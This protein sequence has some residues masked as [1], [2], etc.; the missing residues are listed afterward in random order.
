MKASAAAFLL[1]AGCSVT[2]FEDVHR[3]SDADVARLVDQAPFPEKTPTV[4]PAPPAAVEPDAEGRK[5]IRLDLKE[6]LRLALKNNKEFLLEG[7]AIDVQLLTLEVLRRNWL[8]VLAPITGSYTY[9]SSPEAPH[10]TDE[11]ATAALSQKMPF[12]GNV[13]ASWTHAG[14]QPPGR[15]AYTGV[16]T[17]SYTQPLLRGG[18]R[19]SAFEEI[20]AGER[21]Y[22]Y[23]QRVFDFNRVGLFIKVVESYFRLLQQEDA[24]RNFARNVKAATDQATAAKIRA[25]AG[26]VPQTDLFRSQ[27]QVTNATNQLEISREQLKIALDAFKID[28]GLPPEN[29]IALAPEKIDY[30]P[31]TITREE[32]VESA[33]SRN[34]AWLIAKDKLDDAKRALAL[35]ENASLAKLDT[36]F[37][38]SWTSD[39]AAHPLDPYDT[40]A[41]EFSVTGAFELPIDRYG[42]RR[43]YQKAVIAYRQAERELGR[44]RDGVV[45]DVQSQ[46]TLLAQAE[47]TMQ[48]QQRAIP[49]ALKAARI[50]EFDYQRGRIAN[51][52]VLE[53]QEQHVQAQNAYQQALV[54]ARIAQLRLL[55]FI[56]RLEADAD[57]E[58]LK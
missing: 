23:A 29:D 49:D 19:R 10:T 16:G 30:R 2:G 47:S 5:V 35:A 3:V 32:A 21:N 20:V 22:A 56:G 27:L 18:G 41:R 15:D 40:A 6:C 44:T 38:W 52:D 7:E 57:G 1:I 34:P 53:A 4:Q 14:S 50:A 24:I 58:W 13:A 55:Q 11:S 39:P 45:R 43:D 9:T 36:I 48:F 31:L 25:T 42:L 12:G 8:P 28:L 46:L 26:L 37:A 33:L 17:V 54:S 51:R